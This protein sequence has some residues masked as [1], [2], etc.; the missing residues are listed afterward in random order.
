MWTRAGWGELCLSRKSTC[1]QK[2]LS[3]ELGLARTWFNP[4]LTVSCH[5]WLLPSHFSEARRGFQSVKGGCDTLCKASDF[6]LLTPTAPS[7]ENQK[8]FLSPS[9]KSVHWMFC[10][11]EIFWFSYLLESFSKNFWLDVAVISYKRPLLNTWSKGPNV[12]KQPCLCWQ[13]WSL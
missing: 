12:V 3:Y 11:A 7:H 1:G 9:S 8:P 2:W 13:N 6:H 10:E 4:Q 5:T